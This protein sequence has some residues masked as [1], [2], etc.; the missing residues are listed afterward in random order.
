MKNIFFVIII[1]L[2]CCGLIHFVTASKTTKEHDNKIKFPELRQTNEQL[3]IF[4]DN[5]YDKKLHK[6]NISHIFLTNKSN[7]L[8]KRYF[9]ILKKIKT[10][11]LKNKTKKILI[12]SPKKL[13]T[14][15]KPYKLK[16]EIN[17]FEDK[18]GDG[19]NDIVKNSKL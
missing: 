5:F 4:L 8:R 11:K 9:D 3:K 7:I 10:K 14:K 6:R 16:L 18:N 12:S 15:K 19:I 17:R 2:F 1:L 13:S